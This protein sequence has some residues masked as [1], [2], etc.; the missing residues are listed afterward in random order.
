MIFRLVSSC[1]VAGCCS[2]S[3]VGTFCV[4]FSAVPTEKPTSVTALPALDPPLFLS[5]NRTDEGVLLQ[6]LPPEAPSS[7]L[8]GFMLQARRDQGQWLTLTKDISGNQSE[9][10]VQ[11]LFRVMN[12]YCASQTAVFP[13][14]IL[15]CGCKNARR[16]LIFASLRAAFMI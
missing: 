2:I 6:W 9:L 4:F 12:L 16:V 7:P 3:D 14:Y 11:G 13:E 10:L 8:T 5:A 15:Y 1:H